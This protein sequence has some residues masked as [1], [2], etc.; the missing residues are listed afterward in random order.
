LCRDQ[1]ARR[2]HVECLGERVDD[3]HTIA[4]DA[5]VSVHVTLVGLGQPESI[6][7]YMIDDR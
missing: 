7:D 4:N 3:S 1:H 6:D 2:A 5:R